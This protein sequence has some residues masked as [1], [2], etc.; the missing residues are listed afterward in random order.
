M[1]DFNNDV[2]DPVERIWKSSVCQEFPAYAEYWKKW[3][4]TRFGQGPM[5]L[6]G[7][8]L[9]YSPGHQAEQRNRISNRYDKIRATHYGIFL[10]LANTHYSLG[11]LSNNLTAL[12]GG[13]E[14]DTALVLSAEAA[15]FVSSCWQCL[16]IVHMLASDLVMHVHR[17]DS[18][19]PSRINVEGTLAGL[20]SD[21]EKDEYED[22]WDKRVKP[23]RDSYAHQPPHTIKIAPGG[24]WLIPRYPPS[25]RS[26]LTWAG[27]AEREEERIEVSQ[28]ISD[29]LQETERFFNR[30]WPRISDMMED[31]LSHLEVT[32]N[33]ID[34][35]GN[36]N[37]STAYV[38]SSGSSSV[39]TRATGST[40]QSTNEIP[41]GD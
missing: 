3:I 37:I 18:K 32:I 36:S 14:I 13:V 24:Y 5:D 40:T 41:P 1:L 26:N 34:S 16:G 19:C 6:E 2:I 9:V 39:V 23:Y 10:N 30:I 8:E 21:D 17:L 4:G 25:D 11:H 12:Y 31:R 38:Q 35:P 33:Y 28:Y 15:F 7:Y 22:L 27:Q 29:C 20:L